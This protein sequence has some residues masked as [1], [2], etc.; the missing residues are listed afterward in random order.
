[1]ITKFRNLMG[2]LQPRIPRSLLSGDGWERLLGRV[3]NLPESIAA[4]LCGF[5]L[6]LDDPAPAADFSVAVTPGPVARHFLSNSNVA[7]NSFEGWLATY[8]GNWSKPDDWIMLAYDI[9][10]VPEGQQV[11]PTVY[12][13]NEVAS[14]TDET[15]LHL[16]Q[17]SQTLGGILG[18]TGNYEKRA[19]ARIFAAL[20]PTA[21]VV[22]AAATPQRM[23][24]SV[25]LVVSALAMPQLEQFLTRLE[26]PGSIPTIMHMLSEMR[27]V[28]ER[29]MIACDVNEHGILPRLGFEMYPTTA[30]AIN[31][32]DLLSTWLTTKRTDW[33]RLIDHLVDMNLCLREKS[34]GLLSWPKS[35]NVYGKAGAYRLYMGINH[36]KL[37]LDGERLRAK[38][39]VGMKCQRFIDPN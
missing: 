21:K 7:T 35:M 10:D 37:V 32:Y 18:E 28:S 5:E 26:W 36:V 16:N 12:L 3:G 8:L 33:C 24:R 13:R 23:P 15:A 29:F 27:Q 38:A 17:L 4:N 22:F 11:L 6:K 14:M 25:R 2:A 31:D 34:E 39:Y 30:P 1:M 19:L 20:P 9:I